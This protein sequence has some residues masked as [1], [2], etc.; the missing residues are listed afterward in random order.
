MVKFS[1][2]PFDVDLDI[3]D[4]PYV[5]LFG[6]TR[7]GNKICVKHEFY[8]YIWVVL[9]GEEGEVRNTLENIDEVDINNI[10]KHTKILAGKEIDVLKVTL[11]TPNQ[12]PTL[13]NILEKK[14]IILLEGDILYT[15]R[16]L[17]D[18]D[19]S[20]FREYIVEGEETT[21][22][23]HCRCVIVDSIKKG[24]EILAIII[25]ADFHSKGT[26]FFT[27]PDFSQQLAFI[28]R[29]AGEIINAH[30]HNIT[31]RDIHFTRE[32]LF[33]KKGKIKI[34]F[35]DS[36]RNYFVFRILSTGDVILLAGGGHG[37]KFLEDTEMIEI[38]QGPYLGED[39]KAVF[40]GIEK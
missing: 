17:I 20:M 33:I 26:K 18:N 11:Q 19:I 3:E 36:K 13:R 15:R 39:D 4:K 2:F 22:F 14:G 35:Y 34:N 1:F 23:P 24:D 12:M 31:K 27:P 30:I 38:K 21:P 16:Y 5:L 25:P 8:P 29:K 9:N 37:F 28:S 40:K 32:V 10:E 6:R 7:E